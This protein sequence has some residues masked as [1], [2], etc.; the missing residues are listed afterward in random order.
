MNL[1]GLRMYVCTK[2]LWR[3]FLF[4]YRIRPTR[5]NLYGADRI[6][7]VAAARR[8]DADVYVVSTRDRAR[9]ETAKFEPFYVRFLKCSCGRF[10]AYAHRLP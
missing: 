6:C 8:V 7:G 5:I 9:V 10:G 2:R 3:M 4:F 1:D